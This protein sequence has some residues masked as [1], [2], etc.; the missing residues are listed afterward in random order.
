VVPDVDAFPGHI[1]CDPRTRSEIVLPHLGPDR[2]PI[3]AL[4]LDSRLPARFDEEDRAGL[5]QVL[6]LLENN[7]LDD[8][9]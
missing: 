4:D 6:G 8:P 2:T 3:G 9:N 5:H 1:A 7:P